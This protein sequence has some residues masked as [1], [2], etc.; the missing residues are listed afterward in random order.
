MQSSHFC[1]P[2]FCILGGVA[3]R[4]HKLPLH[5]QVKKLFS[6]NCKA[7]PRRCNKSTKLKLVSQAL[8]IQHFCIEEVL[9]S[10]EFCGLADLLCAGHTAE[11]S[12]VL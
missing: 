7:G 5:M 9:S 12:K 2:V 11:N 4:N 3:L 8:F 1:V 6:T 10:E